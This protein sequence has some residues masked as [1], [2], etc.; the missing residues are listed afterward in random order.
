MDGSVVD[1]YKLRHWL[2]ARKVTPDL[3]GAHTAVSPA[4]LNEIL[5]HRRTR[6]PGRDAAELA[7]FLNIT[8]GQ[9][10]G[11]DDLPTVLHQTAEQLKATGRTVERGGI[12]FYNYYTLPAPL[13][14]IAPV[15]LDILCPHDR[16]PELN[17]GHLEPAITVNLGP[18]DINGRW[19]DELSD[20]TWSV[21]RANRD[22]ADSWIVG[23]SYV[24]PPY[25]PHTY[26]LASREPARILS[27]TTRSNLHRFTEGLNTWGE[28]AFARL[29]ADLG[30]A[31]EG[32]ALLTIELARRGFDAPIA[33]EA[34][35]VDP[36][37]VVAYLQDRTSALDPADIIALSRCLGLDYRTLL[38]VHRSHDAVGK[39]YGSF[40]DSIAGIRRF[41][42]Y[43]VA[44]MAASPQLPDLYGLFVLVDNRSP[45]FEPDLCE[46]GPTHYLVTEGSPLL[47]W[48]GSD[49]TSRST[50][51]GVDDSLWVGAC[52]TH[53]FS[54]QGALIKM[55]GGEGYSYLDRMEMTNTFHTDAT[56][57][58]G[59]HDR[60][61]WGDQEPAG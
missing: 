32:A 49:G 44:S 19:G 47:H 51:L 18:G 37:R 15:I 10:G 53:G 12:E 26:S 5:R 28:P 24:E 61:G 43:T 42:S 52:V 30:E 20:A 6:L 38:P 56:L 22:P 16:L 48:T 36:E 50:E 21:L 40:D 60:I 59:R 9:L 46:H 4:V 54:G 34:A 55:S 45:E 2:N 17:N 7:D 57:R 13:G 25:C 11:D 39:T 29:T 33:A 3:V 58:R 35:G 31:P 41:R 1:P 14:W 27:Y 8:V 23:D